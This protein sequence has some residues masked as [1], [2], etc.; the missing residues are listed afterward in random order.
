MSPAAF[1]ARLLIAGFAGPF[2]VR[3]PSETFVVDRDDHFVSMPNPT[4]SAKDRLWFAEQTA[5][6]LNERAGLSPALPQAAE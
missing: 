5:A 1:R 4:L 3:S 2:R 6:D